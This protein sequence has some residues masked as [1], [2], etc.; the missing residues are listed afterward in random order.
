MWNL[1]SLKF[2]HT[3][4]PTALQSHRSSTRFKKESVNRTIA[5]KK[6]IID[7]KCKFYYNL[8]EI[9]LDFPIFMCFCFF[10][11]CSKCKKYLANI[12]HVIVLVKS[13]ENT[14][15]PFCSKHLR[16]V[17]NGYEKKENQFHNPP[18]SCHLHRARTPIK[19]SE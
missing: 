4:E 12:V 19:W 11:F 13:Q 17:Q 6:S 7:E 16:H 1:F 3:I 9:C 14:S 8:N 2:K 18:Y 15:R 5:Q 10:F